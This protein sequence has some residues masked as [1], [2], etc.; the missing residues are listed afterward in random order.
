[1]N[2]PLATGTQNNTRSS[3]QERE[4][5][6]DYLIVGAGISG[7]GAACHLRRHFSGC[8]LA[9]VEVKDDFGGTWHT[10]RYPGARSDSDLY[11]YGYSFKPWSGRSIATADEIRRYMA[12]VIAENDL[13]AHIR[14]RH[15]V[16]QAA[17]CSRQKRWTLHMTRLDT[18]EELTLSANFLWMCQGYY[19][20]EQGYTPQWPGFDDFAGTVIHPQRWPEGETCAGQRVVVIGSGATAATLI[21]ALAQTARHITMLQRSPTFFFAEPWA[22]ELEGPLRALKIP[23]TWVHEIMRR[24]H[25][26]RGAEVIRMS[27][28]EP[29]TLRQA[30][31]EQARARLPQGFDV[32]KHFN[33]RYRPWQQRIALLPD[34]DLFTAISEG[35]AAVVT[36]QIDHFDAQGIVLQ[37]GARL[38]ADVIITATGFNMCLFGGIAFSVDGKALDLREHV[39]WRGLMME[40]V[41]N[42]AYVMG[43]LR[44]SWTLRL[45][46]ICDLVCRI[47]DHMHKQGVQVVTPRLRPEDT[48]MPRLPWGDPENFNA[49]YIMRAQHLMFRQGDRAPWQQGIEYAQEK[50]L[51]PTVQPQEDAL[52]YA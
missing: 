22:H 23:D 21:P 6:F 16:T 9:I 38:D 39:T 40:G 27:F 14:Y 2:P 26:A 5:H 25:I 1:M 7:I 52:V 42:M 8:R 12:E 43:Y 34:G 10:H 49:G 3:T 30:L 18:G 51:L 45:D 15:Q 31:I 19:Q 4:T 29:E 17:W 28:E 35:K 24:A 33:P 13:Q 44:S 50:D 41:P 11:T 48:D 37:S 46:M 36:D 47:I 32:D 20:H